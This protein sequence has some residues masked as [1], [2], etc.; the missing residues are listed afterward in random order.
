MIETMRH[1]LYFAWRVL[2]NLARQPW[3]LIAS[4]MQPII[5]LLLAASLFSRVAQLPG[6]GWESYV[7][8]IAPGLVIMGA[9]FA[10]GWNG[11][12]VIGDIDR[13]VMDRLLV[14]PMRRGALVAGKL[15]QLTVLVVVQT[16]ILVVVAD[17]RGATF[18]NGVSGMLALVAA[19]VLIAAPVGALS[20]SIA[21]ATR[22]V[23]SLIAGAS[24][25]LMP[26]T[27]LTSLFMPRQLV[28]HWIQT[29]APYDPADWAGTA[30]RVAV[31][32]APD[33][34]AVFVRFGYLAA[35][36]VVCVAIAVRAF[37]SYLR[38]V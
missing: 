15:V 32:P 2:R 23:E 8:Y 24:L 7:T 30:A 28:P 34:G 25:V 9:I 12:G 29:V 3:F 19:A 22:N 11:M 33:W 16:A 20:T 37:R 35:L 13:G 26:M 14:T 31:G 27:L 4:V 18:E 17:L 36:T 10:G 5:L 1:T 6:F 21:L 38:S